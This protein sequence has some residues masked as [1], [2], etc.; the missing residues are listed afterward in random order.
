MVFYDVNTQKSTAQSYIIP[1]K[2]SQITILAVMALEEQR[3]CIIVDLK[4][5]ATLGSIES[6]CSNSDY[7]KLCIANRC[8]LITK[9]HIRQMSKPDRSSDL[10]KKCGSCITYD[11]ILASQKCHQSNAKGIRNYVEYLCIDFQ[12]IVYC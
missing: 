6:N 2:I 12:R 9:L 10:C 11:L 3:I 4:P 8:L 7:S 1:P 5:K